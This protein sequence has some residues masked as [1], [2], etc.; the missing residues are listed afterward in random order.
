M[1]TSI[2]SIAEGLQEVVFPNVCL[3]CGLKLSEKENFVCR[4]CLKERFENANVDGLAISGDSMLPEG[5]ALQHALW[6]FD[7]GGYLQDLLHQ[8]KYHRLAGVGV[9]L[10]KQLGKS[11]KNNPHFVFEKDPI[12]IPVPLHAGKKRKRGYNQA[13]YIAKGLKIATSI[14]IIK[15]K[16]VVRVKNTRTQTG[17]TLEKRR[18]NIE[19][20]F[21]VDMPERVHARTC[22]IVDDVFT[23]GAT[24]FELARVLLEAGAYKIMITSVAQA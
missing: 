18:K 16:A 21:R 7:K 1:L 20:A 5:I 23:T 2:K 17:F 12:L 24:S 15:Q 8:L 11:L 14:P 10:G 19:G 13:Y 6:K 3:V 9:D 22:I 4:S